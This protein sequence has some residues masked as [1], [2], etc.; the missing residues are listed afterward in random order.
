MLVGSTLFPFIYRGPSS[1]DY[2]ARLLSICLAFGPL[3]TLLSI[4]YEMLFYVSFCATILSWLEMERALYGNASRK[5]SR[6]LQGGDIRAALL[7][8]FFINV[9]FF[10]TGNIASLSSFSLAS[11]YRFVTIFNPFLMGALLIVKI[12]IPF[13]AVSAVL[14]VLSS[15]LDLAPFSIFMVVLS[16][17][18]IQTIN[19]FY[20]VS[21]FGSWLEIGTSIS[22]FCIAELFI[23]F[24]IIL[25]LLSRLLVGHLIISTPETKQKSS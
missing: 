7:F 5:T 4:S 24:T 11:V 20:F 10:G 16:V 14:G 25:F 9:A 2:L 6:S 23:T 21:D 19:F 8:M 1:E 3:M 15:S 17:T 13:F 18:D 22:H 12:L